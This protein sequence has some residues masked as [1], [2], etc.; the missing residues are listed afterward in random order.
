MEPASPPPTSLRPSLPL[1]FGKTL[2]ER[3]LRMHISSPVRTHGPGAAGGRRRA[4]RTCPFGCGHGGVWPRAPPSRPGDT[5]CALCSQSGWVFLSPK[6][7]TASRRRGWRPLRGQ[8]WTEPGVHVTSAL[9]SRPT[10]PL[11]GLIN[12]AQ[13]LVCLR[14]I[15]TPLPAL[16]RWGEICEVRPWFRCN[17]FDWTTF[18]LSSFRVKGAL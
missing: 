1:R 9:N 3:G 7:L 8:L 11:L 17:R 5:A 13:V 12:A 4:T 15:N 16:G 14:L 18:L 6:F 2:T 10:W